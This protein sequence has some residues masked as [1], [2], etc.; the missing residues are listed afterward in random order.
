MRRA[1]VI[2]LMLVVC[3]PAAA[4][5][6]A[7]VASGPDGGRIFSI[8]RSP[9]NPDVV[10]ALGDVVWRSVDGGA[11]WASYLGP[12][13]VDSLF[14]LQVGGGP[15]DVR[16]GYNR[17]RL[18]RSIGVGRWQPVSEGYS[19]Y[20]SWKVDPVVPTRLIGVR[21][22]GSYLT[23]EQCWWIEVERSTDGGTTFANSAT[24]FHR[25]AAAND[26]TIAFRDGQLAP[27][28]GVAGRSW[29][30]VHDVSAHTYLFRTDDAGSTWQPETVPADI[31]SLSLPAPGDELV[32]LSL[33]GLTIQHRPLGG[34]DW[35]TGPG[36][37]S[38]L[39]PEP[40]MLAQSMLVGCNGTSGG[41]NFSGLIAAAGGSPSLA[42]H[43]YVGVARQSGSTWVPSNTGLAAQDITGAVRLADGSIVI[44]GQ[45]GA[46]RQQP[47]GH[48]TAWNDGLPSGPFGG[49]TLPV[50]V[51]HLHRA[52]V[53]AGP[54]YRRGAADAAWAPIATPLTS[55]YGM[56]GG[57]V[58]SQPIYIYSQDGAYASDDDGAAW[59]HMT[60]LPDVIYFMTA[61]STEPAV[62]YA[63]AGPASLQTVIGNIPRMRLYRTLDGG[64]TWHPTSTA[65]TFFGFAIDPADHD[66]L[67][68]FDLTQSAIVVTHDA[69]ATWHGKIGSEP[70]TS[71]GTS[72]GG[73]VWAF[74]RDA[75]GVI[76]AGTSLAGLWAS[77]DDGVTWGSVAGSDTGSGI[78]S[79]LDEGAPAPAATAGR[80]ASAWRLYAT[81]ANAGSGFARIDA[82]VR[83]AHLQGTPR[84]RGH[85]TERIATCTGASVVGGSPS[86]TIWL[87]GRDR[88]AT[89][90][91]VRLPA[92]TVGR[93]VRCEFRADTP[94]ANVFRRSNAITPV[95]R[96]FP[97]R[98]ALVVRRRVGQTAHCSVTWRGTPTSVTYLWRVG[99]RNRGTARQYTI[100]SIDVGKRLTCT[101]TATNRY[102]R[103][104]S[105]ATAV[106]VRH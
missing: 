33:D 81:V 43:P 28:P 25:C 38:G 74:D 58:A 85:R 92:S 32:G 40:F 6:P 96:P 1:L 88:V 102:G 46:Y 75:A 14:D 29:L 94:Y 56:T 23:G 67:I 48:W 34:G 87:A 42:S 99:G 20:D 63:A 97:V 82:R 35:T 21:L 2:F 80:A 98:R 16:Y 59:R 89:G 19:S 10:Y 72:G 17:Q 22:A 91:R 64:I 13:R 52:L 69:G 44:T 4:A 78:T 55:V 106:K 101:A 41:I 86:K 5:P 3:G 105:T 70:R 18:Y 30:L 37:C 57:R 49:G 36:A 61:S 83:L 8:A 27:D 54:L 24:F 62:A 73:M 77:A 53:A 79:F 9:S 50:L 51:D 45:L 60:G 11:H 26:T 31:A 104:T 103:R 100:R 39:T 12:G 84:L 47:D 95:G 76:Y 90:R 68:T 65:G 66:H 7:W 93:Q 71:N 15:G